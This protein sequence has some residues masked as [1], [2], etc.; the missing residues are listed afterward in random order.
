MPA[1][2]LLPPE[3]NLDVAAADAA[4]SASKAR[5]KSQTPLVINVDDQVKVVSMLHPGQRQHKAV[6]LK[7]NGSKLESDTCIR[8]GAVVNVCWQLLCF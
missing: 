3:K 4:P 2:V 7:V 5:R 8:A 6:R 1:S